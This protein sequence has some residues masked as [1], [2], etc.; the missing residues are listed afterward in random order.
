VAGLTPVVVAVRR[1]MPPLSFPLFHLHLSA[2][3][4]SAEP[5]LVRVISLCLYGG[6][7]EMQRSW[8]VPF[9]SSQVYRYLTTPALPP[10]HIRIQRSF[11]CNSLVPKQVMWEVPQGIMQCVWCGHLRLIR[12]TFQK[13]VMYCCSYS[14]FPACFNQY[15][16]DVAFIFLNARLKYRNTPS[17]PSLVTP[18]AW[19]SGREPCKTTRD[20]HSTW[21]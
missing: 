4:W 7:D 9:L 13:Y 5:P 11:W 20:T 19:R 16:Q 18:A 6:E 21:P 10:L 3:L 8:C 12:V 14:F 1:V 17:G 15:I 2:S